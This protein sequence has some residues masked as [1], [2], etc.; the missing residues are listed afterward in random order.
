MTPRYKA[1]HIG[2]LLSIALVFICSQFAV[3]AEVQPLANLKR[4]ERLWLSLV[5]GEVQ[6][7]RED[8]YRSGSET[9]I[10]FYKT[11]G[12]L[13]EK[14]DHFATID[15]KQ[16]SFDKRQLK[17]E[18]YKIKK[19]LDE[20]DEQID[21]YEDDVQESIDKLTED[22]L[23]LAEVIE[24]Q[25]SS[26]NIKKRAQTALTEITAEITELEKKVTT[27]ELKEKSKFDREELE[28]KL[29]KLK[30]DFR[31]K[32]KASILKARFSGELTISS[33]LE[34]QD[35]GNSA[36]DVLPATLF[37]TITD[38]SH[39]EIILP[40]QDSAFYRNDPQSLIL[41]CETANSDQY[42]NAHFKETRQIDIGGR[43]GTAKVFQFSEKSNAIAAANVGN[44]ITAYVFIKFKQPYYLVEKKDLALIDPE[45][46]KNH[47]WPGLVQKFYPTST[48][49]KIGP[50]SIAIDK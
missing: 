2:N 19:L 41:T 6:P 26:K 22:K 12:S 21:K 31:R 28:L 5:E 1:Q 25:S 18:E 46:L 38:K 44:K 33:Q 3:V 8:H 10:T 47:G 17:L 36:V 40:S 50:K 30:E 9:S 7:A 24:Q 23:T 32:E 4:S 43:I 37:A 20:L 39:Y 45:T 35:I 16:L 15:A 42:L 29:E 14:D 34:T 11:D 13:L 49:I 27:D 48:L